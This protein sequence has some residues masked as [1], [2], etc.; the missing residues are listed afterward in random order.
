MKQKGAFEYV[1]EL[2]DWLERH[3]RKSST[4]LIGIDG[5]GGSGKSTL[6]KKIA[7]FC[8]QSVIVHMDDFYLPSHQLLKVKPQNK[9]IGADYDWVRMREQVL[10]PLRNNEEGFYQRYDWNTDKLDD[11]HT[12]PVGGM[13]LVEGVYS[14]RNELKDYY[15]CMIWVQC[16]RETRL[17]RGLERDGEGARDRWE[18]DWMISEDVYMREQQPERRADIIISGTNYLKE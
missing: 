16:P 3:P 17:A 2:I 6:A 14:T 12:V 7:S 11:W 9:P 5:C 10:V 1:N 15:D 13:V 8:P 18:N 4:L